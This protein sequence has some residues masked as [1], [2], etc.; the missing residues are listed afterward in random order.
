[1][2]WLR[3]GGEGATTASSPTPSRSSNRSRRAYRGSYI[4][5]PTS[6]TRKLLAIPSLTSS[7]S[8]RNVPAA[9]EGVNA[10]HALYGLST[11]Y[12]AVAQRC[13]ACKTTDSSG[14]GEDI[15]EDR[16]TDLL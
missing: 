12:R 15:G 9:D 6:K 10:V 7:V 3:S 16:D 13:G 14:K 4:G 2:R 1:M 8:R 11:R 5:P